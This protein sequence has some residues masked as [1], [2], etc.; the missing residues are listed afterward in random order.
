[1]AAPIRNVS[2]ASAGQVGATPPRI[3]NRLAIRVLKTRG[4][5][6]RGRR[7]R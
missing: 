4:V 3:L 5:V 7:R 1:M 2:D 6:G